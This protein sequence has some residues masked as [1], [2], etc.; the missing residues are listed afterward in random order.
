[1][2]MDVQNIRFINEK[3]YRVSWKADGTRLGVMVTRKIEGIVSKGK[4]S[5][6][7]CVCARKEE[8]D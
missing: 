2:S 6:C 1:M 3:P 8:S 5:V 4:G 7:V